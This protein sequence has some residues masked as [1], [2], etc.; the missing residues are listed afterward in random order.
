MMADYKSST[1]KKQRVQHISIR[2][3]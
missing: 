1:G 2:P 3:Y